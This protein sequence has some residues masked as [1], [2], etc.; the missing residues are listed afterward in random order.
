MRYARCGSFRNDRIT[1]PRCNPRRRHRRLFPADGCGRGRHGPG[2]QGASGRHPADDLRSGRPGDRH[3]R[4]WGPGRVRQR[5]GGR[6]MRASDSEDHGESQRGRR[7]KRQCGFASAS[8]S[9]TSSSTRP[10]SM[11]TGST[12][13]PV[14][15]R[16]PTRGC[17]HS[18]NVHDELRGRVEAAFEDIG[19]RE[20]KNIARPVR[21]YV[22]CGKGTSS[23]LDD[24]AIIRLHRSA[25]SRSAAIHQYERRSRAGVFCRRDNGRHHHGPVASKVVFSDRAQLVVRLQRQGGRHSSGRSRTRCS[26]RAGR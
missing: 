19:E 10:G 11:V 21:A 4:R 15:R 1:S 2:A 7:P 13:R 16:S 17:R 25:F 20:L 14:C 6:A 5:S 22:T 3:G 12:L 9:A 23:G 24:A 26:L 18:G 8:I